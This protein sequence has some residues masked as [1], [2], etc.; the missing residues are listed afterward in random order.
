MTTYLKT[1]GHASGRKIRNIAPVWFAWSGFAIAV[2]LCV[3]AW[4]QV[5]RDRYAA[6]C[7]CHSIN[8]RSAVNE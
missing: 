7:R 3:L 5:I 8:H 1:G 4:V 2:V 6:P